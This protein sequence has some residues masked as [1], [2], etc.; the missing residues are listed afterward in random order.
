MK[1]V[2]EGRKVNL[3]RIRR[4]D[5]ATLAERID[6]VTVARN[7]FIPHPYA[8]KDAYQF[9]RKSQR[10]WRQGTA[11]HWMI[12][13]PADGT[14]IGAVGIESISRKHLNCEAGYWLWK[15]YRGRGVMT[16]AVTMAV[17]WAFRE[18]NMRRVQAHVM[19]GNE[20]SIKVLLKCGFTEEGLMRKRIKH[21]GRWQDLYIYSVLRE[22]WKM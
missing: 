15:K 11:Y 22:E 5:A 13:N 16:E 8:L 9:I 12:E 14:V 18:L 6:D 2:I 17:D 7:T 1:T 21:R 3:R 19:R 4:S 20:A 10:Q